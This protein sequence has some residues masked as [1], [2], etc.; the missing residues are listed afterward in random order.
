M[1]IRDTQNVRLSG[2][3]VENALLASTT[4][5]LIDGVNNISDLDV[6]IKSP[7]GQE[8]SP[9]ITRTNEDECKVEWIPY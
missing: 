5:F 6:K 2:P 3:I 4:S 1:F 7:S 9:K 8:F